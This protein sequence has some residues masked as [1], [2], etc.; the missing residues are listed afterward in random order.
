MN[1]NSIRY[2][3]MSGIWCWQDCSSSGSVALLYGWLHLFWMG[4][5]SF[6]SSILWQCSVDFSGVQVRH[7]RLPVQ[8]LLLTKARHNLSFSIVCMLMAGCEPN[9]HHATETCWKR[10]KTSWTSEICPPGWHSHPYWIAV[11]FSWT[12]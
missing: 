7:T 11:C 10:K 5:G 2:C 12:K 8:C 4:F 6:L 3:G 1:N 9:I